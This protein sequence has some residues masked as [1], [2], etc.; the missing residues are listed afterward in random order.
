L[1][2]LGEVDSFH[3]C[4]KNVPVFYAHVHSLF[5]DS[6]YMMIMSSL[7]RLVKWMTTQD[8]AVKDQKLPSTS[9]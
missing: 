9:L 7:L 2:Y 3:V 6:A 5:T 1:R 4:V 8:S